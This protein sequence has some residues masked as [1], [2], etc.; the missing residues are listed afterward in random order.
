M[1]SIFIQFAQILVRQVLMGASFLA[2]LFLG[3]Y[4]YQFLLQSRRQDLSPAAAALLHLFRYTKRI[5][6]DL[7]AMHNGAL[8]S[9]LHR[10]VGS[11]DCTRTN[12]MLGIALH[13]HVVAPGR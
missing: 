7:F 5:F 12:H 3:W 4:E 6:D 13:P 11:H 2:N 8:A 10:Q 9:F 1:S